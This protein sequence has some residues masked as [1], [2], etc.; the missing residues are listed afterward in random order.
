MSQLK[1]FNV[2]N[3]IMRAQKNV[4]AGSTLARREKDRVATDASTGET[5]KQNKNGVTQH[6]SRHSILPCQREYQTSN[7]SRKTSNPPNQPNSTAACAPVRELPHAGRPGADA[8]EIEHGEAGHGLRGAWEGHF[9]SLLAGTGAVSIQYLTGT[10][11][12]KL[13]LSMGLT[14]VP[15]VALWIKRMPTTGGQHTWPHSSAD[16]HTVP[17]NY[18]IQRCLGVADKGQLRWSP[19][20]Q[21][22]DRR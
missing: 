9:W 10:Q 5:M 6:Q 17:V 4:H 12:S 22:S 16:K 7:N 13:Q 3:E 21:P 8:G 20:P 19:P 1:S 11:F 15:L 18:P 2:S 14:R